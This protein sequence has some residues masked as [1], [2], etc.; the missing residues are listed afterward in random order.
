MIVPLRHLLGW[1]VSSAICG[2][3][4]KTIQELNWKPFILCST[5]V[6]G[7]VPCTDSHP[8]PLAG[9]PSHLP[10]DRCFL[11]VSTC[12]RHAQSRV[13]TRPCGDFGRSVTSLPMRT[14]LNQASEGN[15]L[16]Q[17]IGLC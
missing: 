7:V 10:F 2:G 6:A 13:L 5:S 1:M 16:S 17:T 15:I 12:L 3:G 8:P 4:G 11:G 14:S 9:P